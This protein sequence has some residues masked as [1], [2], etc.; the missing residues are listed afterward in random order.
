VPK[1]DFGSLNKV[2]SSSEPRTL[3]RSSVDRR[4]SRCDSDLREGG[5]SDAAVS[6]R[7]SAGKALGL[8]GSLGDICCKFCDVTCS[9]SAESSRCGTESLERLVGGRNPF[10]AISWSTGRRNL[11]GAGH[12][13]GRLRKRRSGRSRLRLHHTSAG[14]TSVVEHRFLSIY[15]NDHLA[16]AMLGVE[17]VRRAPRENRGSAL[18]TFLGE[19]LVPEI[20]EDRQTLE[21]LMGQLGITRSRSKIAAAWT[22]EKLG[23]LKLNGEL[24]NYSPLSRLLELEGLT[25]GI[26]AKRS[27]WLSLREAIAGNGHVEAVDFHALAERA[28]SQQS[29][30]E[31]HRLAAAAEA[32]R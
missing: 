12:S 14:T 29:R 8:P 1:S 13:D 16:G 11:H 21:H 26:E 19:T 20:A 30:L 4:G 28:R 7:E 5:S 6:G 24:R 31:E 3:Q 15:L 22:V 25:A 18:G 9:S 17:L 10:S 2:A 23:R 27:L 32:L